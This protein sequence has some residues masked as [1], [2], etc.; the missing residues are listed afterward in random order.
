[1]MIRI[2]VLSIMFALEGC[3]RAALASAASARRFGDGARQ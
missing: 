1:M 3:G 2:S